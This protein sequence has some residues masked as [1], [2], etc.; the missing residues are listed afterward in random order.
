MRV[1]PIPHVGVEHECADPQGRRGGCDRRELRQW[2]ATRP[3]M[4]GHQQDV[5]ASS[6]GTPACVDNND[7]GAHRHLISE[8]ER[9]WHGISVTPR[10]DLGVTI[11]DD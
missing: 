5:K 3:D 2:G 6:L 7:F 8:S 11:I 9:L 4:V 10:S 1:A